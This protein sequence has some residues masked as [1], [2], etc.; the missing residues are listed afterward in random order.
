MNSRKKRFRRFDHDKI[1]P[2]ILASNLLFL[3]SQSMGNLICYASSS[4]DISADG[5]KRTQADS[6]GLASGSTKKQEN[7]TKPV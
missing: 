2:L 7:G 1:H 3:Y 4:S 5:F 6:E